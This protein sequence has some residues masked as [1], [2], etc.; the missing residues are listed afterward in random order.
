MEKNLF[1]FTPLN[2]FDR[3]SKRDQRIALAVAD[4]AR[5]LPVPELPT[6]PYTRHA[7]HLA[8]DTLAV[9]DRL[10]K[11]IPEPDIP[12]LRGLR[13]YPSILGKGGVKLHVQAEHVR[14]SVNNLIIAINTMLSNE[15]KWPTGDEDY[16]GRF[17]SLRSDALL[18]IEC[19]RSLYDQISEI[20][21]GSQTRFVECPEDQDFEPW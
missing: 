19:L 1:N 5:G 17:D 3:M 2:L 15:Q 20:Q 13:Q 8:E 16:H 6:E 7:S 10:N 4:K 18:K 21:D 11:V 14:G 9:I 12:Y